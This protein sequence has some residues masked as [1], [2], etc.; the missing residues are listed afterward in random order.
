[1]S[2]ECKGSGILTRKPSSGAIAMKPMPFQASVR[3]NVLLWLSF[4]VLASLTATPAKA[5]AQAAAGQPPEGPTTLPP[6]A[7]ISK[8]RVV[9]AYSRDLWIASREAGAVRRLT[10]HVGAECV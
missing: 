4:A 5:P 9:F 7:D 6:F 10:T 2:R 3:V 8:D 1:M